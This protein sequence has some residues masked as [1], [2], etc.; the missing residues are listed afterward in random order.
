[1]DQAVSD[2]RAD[3][4]ACLKVLYGADQMTVSRVG[5]GVATTQLECWVES[6]K[7]VFKTFHF[8]LGTLDVHLGRLAET[9]FKTFHFQLQTLYTQPGSCHDTLL[10]IFEDGQLFGTVVNEEG[11]GSR[12]R[13]HTGVRHHV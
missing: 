8:H 6:C 3:G 13:L 2:T 9:G 5:Q 4:F 1:M 7:A 10:Q 12:G 11:G